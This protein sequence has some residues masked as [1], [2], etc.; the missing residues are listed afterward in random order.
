MLPNI[1]I[2]RVLLQE[3]AHGKHKRKSSLSFV[4]SHIKY[5]CTRKI[6]HLQ[7]MQNK[8]IRNLTIII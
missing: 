7:L 6:E 1:C 2:K 3:K 5:T 4:F 8:R